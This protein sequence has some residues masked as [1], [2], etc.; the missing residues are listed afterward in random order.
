MNSEDIHKTA[1][2]THS[3]HYEYLVMPFGLTN[4]PATFQNLMNTVF[5]PFLRKFVLIFFDDILIYSASVE[6]HIHHLGQVF[7]VMRQ[8]NLYAKRSKCD[9]ATTRVEY[10]GH[11]IEA[12]GVSTDPNKVKA[13]KEWPQPNGLKQLRGFLGLVGYYRKFVRGFGGIARPLTIL[14]K[15]DSFCWSEEAQ[16]AFDD[17]K[18][19]LCEAPV[20]AI[21]D[22]NKQFVVETDACGSGIGAVLMQEGHPIAY[23]S[24]HLKGKQAH[25]SIYEKEFL[26]VVFAVQ[27]WRHYLLHGHFII[28]TDH[29]ILKYLL[30]QRLNTPIQQQWL[31]KLLEFDYE[32]QYRQSKDNLAADALS[33]VEGSEILSMALSVLECDLLKEIKRSYTDDVL[34]R[35]VIEALKKKT[36]AKKHIT[37]SQET[38]RRKGKLVIPAVF[39]LKNKILAWLHGSSSSG[40]SGRDATHQRVKSLFYWKGMSKD[41]QSYIRSCSV[42]Q[43]CK[44]ET[45]GSPGLEQPLPILTAIWSDISMDFID[46]LPNSFGKTVIFVVVDRLSKAAHFMALSHPYTA[47]SV[48]QAFLDTVYKLHGFP[49]SI[50]SDRDTIFLSD[51]WKELF[52][53]Q[54][55]SLNY[56]S[57]YLIAAW[58][59]TYVV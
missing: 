43:Q 3:G 18:T 47:A 7:E 56:S 28:R 24:R 19:A 34:L 55:V 42:C 33:R 25:L 39:E 22:F 10:L 13:V 12:K 32:I 20:L 17:L 51:F 54:G 31:P 58:R 38:L 27:K 50:V 52:A 23:I 41:I 26:A 48:A 4:A 11:F 53:L 45:I 57:A 36:D 16:S 46:G 35:E 44:Y 14:T 9:F 37:W 49:Q 1:F 2:K 5:K 29:R 15:K 6:E 21:P 30:E 40:H 8:N 59:V